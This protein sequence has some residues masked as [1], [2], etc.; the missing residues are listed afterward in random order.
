M[1]IGD[2]ITEVRKRNGLSQAELAKRSGISQAGISYIEKGLRSPS[3][4]TLELLASALGCSVSY[5]IGETNDPKAISQSYSMAAS[6]DASAD[7]QNDPED[8]WALRE[9]L[10][11]DPNRRILFDAASRVPEKDIMTA[12][13]ILEAF[14]EG[15]DSNE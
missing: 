2:R 6:L 15:K 7:A 8:S 1:G 13:R 10:R 3:T 12:V 14:K 5:L 9:S 11:R 4:D